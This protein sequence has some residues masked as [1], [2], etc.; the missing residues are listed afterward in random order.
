MRDHVTHAPL[1]KHDHM[2]AIS[3]ITSMQM[4]DRQL[5]AEQ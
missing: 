4:P 3:S 5:E 1:K 2:R